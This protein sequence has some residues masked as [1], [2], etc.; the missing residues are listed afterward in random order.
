MAVAFDLVIIPRQIVQNVACPV[1]HRKAQTHVTGVEV[2]WRIAGSGTL[3]VD[4]VGEGV[5]LFLTHEGRLLV[6]E[7]APRPHNS[8]HYTIE[9]CETSQFENHLR[10][11]LDMPLGSPQLRAP[12][13]VMVNLLGTHRAAASPNAPAALAVP[14]A[15]LHLYDKAEVRPGRKMG[16]VTVLAGD[17]E[18]A[19][20]VARR[21]ADEVGL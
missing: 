17:L 21:A 15:H 8:G 1:D 9:A 10:G 18:G 11:V 13:A 3:S 6:N 4:P 12:A 14:G 16:H 5:E 19:K 20:R 2:P 7:V